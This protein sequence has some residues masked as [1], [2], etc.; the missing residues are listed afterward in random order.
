MS[1]TY[2]AQ[3]GFPRRP[4]IRGSAVKESLGYN[5][6]LRLKC[7]TCTLME[8]EYV[9]HHLPYSSCNDIVISSLC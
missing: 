4:A 3:V 2:G 8:Y 7:A 6:F 9:D 5:E 1:K